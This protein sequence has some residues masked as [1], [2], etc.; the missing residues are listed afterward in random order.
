MVL[1]KAGQ[2]SR[3]H[4]SMNHLLAR[5]RQSAGRRIPAIAII[6][7]IIV[8]IVFFIII[9]LTIVIWPAH[10][11]GQMCTQD[12]DDGS[13]NLIQQL[14]KGDDDDNENADDNSEYNEDDQKYAII[15]IIG[16]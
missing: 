1:G 9:N 6:M 8:V 2:A 11:L 12:M 3:G 10:S 13:A 5:N 14:L 7:S 15:A 16:K 4:K